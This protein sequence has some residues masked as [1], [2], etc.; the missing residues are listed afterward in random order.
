MS[1]L[2]KAL[3]YLRDAIAVKLPDS[4]IARR[5]KLLVEATALDGGI[6]PGHVIT[7]SSPINSATP[8][9]SR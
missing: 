4:E 3:R 8:G 9:C 7:G 5:A 2:D 6:Y 1:E